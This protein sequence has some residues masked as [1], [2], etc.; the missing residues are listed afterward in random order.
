MKYREKKK[1]VNFSM[2]AQCEELKK[3]GLTIKEDCEN[4]SK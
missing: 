1:K 3:R 2:W 4:Y